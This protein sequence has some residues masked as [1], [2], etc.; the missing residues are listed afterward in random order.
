MKAK[1]VS[2]KFSELEERVQMLEKENGSPTAITLQKL[3]ERIGELEL[4]VQ[5]LKNKKSKS[6]WY[7]LKFVCF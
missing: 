2:N 1:E 6:L 3:I 5:M 4:E 7:R